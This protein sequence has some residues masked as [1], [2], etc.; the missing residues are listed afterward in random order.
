MQCDD[1]TLAILEAACQPDGG[2][3]GRSHLL[4]FCEAGALSLGE[5]PFGEDVEE[6]YWPGHEP[7]SPHSI[8]L[9]LIQEIY[10][11]RA[12]LPA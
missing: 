9:D 3:D 8:I 4:A 1:V 5:A 6:I 7:E 11:L 10:C 2:P 12:L